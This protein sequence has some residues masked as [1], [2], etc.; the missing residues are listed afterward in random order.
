MSSSYRFHSIYAI[1]EAFEKLQKLG[2]NIKLF[3]VNNAEI[4]K[5]STLQNPQGIL[6]IVQQHNY[7]KINPIFL[8]NSLNL[9][10]DGIQDPGNL[11][12]I[13]RT[14]D[15]FGFK[16]IICSL[17]TADVYNP[18]TVQASMGSLSRIEI[19]YT[20]LA[21][22]LTNQVWVGGAYLDGSNIYNINWPTEGFIVLG[23]EGQ[24]ISENLEKLI[25]HKITI[26]GLSVTESLNVGISSAIFCSE[27]KRSILA[28]K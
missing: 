4:S 26:P 28:K 21:N 9:V 11:G 10:L 18:K 16:N 7:R 5:I 22:L 17:D 19:Y 23:N 3:E 24:G 14:A 6:A 13:I 12:T 27:I 15:W 1:P 2:T 25:T 20:D 8:K